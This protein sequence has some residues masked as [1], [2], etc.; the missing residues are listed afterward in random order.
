MKYL[1]ELDLQRQKIIH[2]LSGQIK[3]ELRIQKDLL[4]QL[5]TLCHLGETKHQLERLSTTTQRLLEQEIWKISVF[6]TLH[7]V[8]Y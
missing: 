8:V 4:E 2:D 6:D 3:T 5:D 7:E 1:E